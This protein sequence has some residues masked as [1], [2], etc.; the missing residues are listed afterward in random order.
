MSEDKILLGYTE[1][2]QGQWTWR[3]ID[4]DG[5]IFAEAT[6]YSKTEEECRGILEAITKADFHIH[7]LPKL[8]FVEISS[9]KAE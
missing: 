9:E 1:H 4:E 7:H 6:R 8:P 2:G 5:K 3:M